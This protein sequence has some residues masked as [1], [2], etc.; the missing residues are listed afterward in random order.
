[1]T[2]PPLPTPPAKVWTHVSKGRPVMQGL[3]TA[4]LKVFEQLPFVVAPMAVEKSIQPTDPA[5]SPPRSSFL[6]LQIGT[7]AS[8]A[9]V[10]SASPRKGQGPCPGTSFPEP[11]QASTTTGTV[12]GNNPEPCPGVQR[13][14]MTPVTDVAWVEAVKELMPMARAK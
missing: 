6:F 2:G 3:S 14:V 8:F 5:L 13:V 4:P 9:V 1:M 7:I 10:V 12:I 11:S